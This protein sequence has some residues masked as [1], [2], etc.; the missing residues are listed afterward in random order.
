[1]CRRESAPVYFAIVEPYVLNLRLGGVEGERSCALVKI[2]KMQTIDDLGRYEVA[3]AFPSMFET[4]IS[5][6]IFILY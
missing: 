5:A 3:L 2:H 1:M 6:E 4:S